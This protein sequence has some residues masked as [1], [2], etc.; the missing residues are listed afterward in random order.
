MKELNE[1]EIQSIIG[2]DQISNFKK[3]VW[4][5][6]KDEIIGDDD[7]NLLQYA[8]QYLAPR[9]V[10]FILDSG[11]YNI[12]KQS[13][14][15]MDTAL[16]IT[17]T[18]YN[19]EASDIVDM[20]FNYHPKVDVDLNNDFGRNAVMCGVYSGIEGRLT[21]K[22]AELTKNLDWEDKS[23]D[24]AITL[25]TYNDTMFRMHAI[26]INIF[27][28][29]GAKVSEDNLRRMLSY[30]SGNTRTSTVWKSIQERE[31]LVSLAIEIASKNEM[32]EFVPDDVQEMFVF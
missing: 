31:D 29:R 3:M 18:E 13:L 12:N 8:C 2:N 4:T 19:D 32:W 9:I 7:L 16:T 11:Y 20:I 21:T 28:Q 25:A 15:T 10:E 5:N 14:K 17:M 24:T 6:Y 27:I 30:I 26:F 1:Q 22:C 23:G